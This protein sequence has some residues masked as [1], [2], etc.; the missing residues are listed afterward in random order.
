MTSIAEDWF[1]DP[2]LWDL[3]A[4]A[5]P[6]VDPTRLSIGQSLRLPPKDARRDPTPSSPVAPRSETT[7]TVR[8]G[9]TL[10]GIARMFYGKSEAWRAIYDANRTVIGDDPAAL[11]VGTTLRIPPAPIGAAKD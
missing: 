7:H 2:G 3:I 11:E 9:D 5:N 4:K 10:S 8:A 1:G 6:F